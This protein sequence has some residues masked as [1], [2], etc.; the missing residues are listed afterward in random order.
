MKYT[1]EE[2]GEYIKTKQPDYSDLENT[3]L[4]TRVLDKYPE[5]QDMIITE[6][7]TVDVQQQPIGLLGR[8]KDLAY[9]VSEGAQRSA[10]D[11]GRLIG[12]DIAE[13]EEYQPQTG[14]GEVS[15][16]ASEYLSPIGAGAGVLGK[17]MTGPIVTGMAKRQAAKNFAQENFQELADI[18]QKYVTKGKSLLKKSPK[19]KIKDKQITKEILESMSDEDVASL[20]S[21]AIQ[22]TSKIEYDMPVD[23][24]YKNKE[25]IKRTSMKDLDSTNYLDQQGR[26]FQESFKKMDDSMRKITDSAIEEVKDVSIDITPTY[27]SVTVKLTDM[28][29]IDESGK[30]IKD[31]SRP[32]FSKTID[33]LKSEPNMTAGQIYRKIQNLD[34]QINYND[35][36][37][38][39]DGLKE[40]RRAFREEL[41]K[42]SPKYD[43]IAT[44]YHDRLSNLPTLEKII[45]DKT[46]KSKLGGGESLVRKNL[47]QSE[48][49]E[50]DRFL[51]DNLDIPSTLETY[52][53]WKNIQG[54]KAWN[55]YFGQNKTVFEKMPYMGS[56]AAIVKDVASS[57][58]TPVEKRVRKLFL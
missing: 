21:D 32:L 5:Y 51:S 42:V 49:E 30:A 53:Q 40:L 31:N 24:F 17:A 23:N 37:P 38:F 16:T 14:L 44:R 50:M 15:M 46:G 19:E 47:K 41:R 7:E 28:G 55:D 45:L 36:N 58:T 8:A 11:L 1:L 6:T 12:V 9:S 2:F 54:W 57:I 39:D 4:A 33:Q 20:K 25:S 48:F 18:S 52:G 13:R 29:L 35:P 27:E 3:D 34:K 10:D 22:E 56:K 26:N 43:D